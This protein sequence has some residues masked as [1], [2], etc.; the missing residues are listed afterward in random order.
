MNITDQIFF[1]YETIITNPIRRLYRKGPRVFGFWENLDNANIC[2]VLSGY[3]NKQ[4]QHVESFWEFNK[5]DCQ[6][7]CM[8][9]NIVVFLVHVPNLCRC[10]AC[11][12]ARDYQPESKPK[13]TLIKTVIY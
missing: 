9:R 2:T 6:Y 8:C 3:S 1:I 13:P 7:S 10:S 12:M 5:N 4:N 11:P